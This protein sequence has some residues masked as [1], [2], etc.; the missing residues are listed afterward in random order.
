MKRH[1]TKPIL[2]EQIA[3]AR[4]AIAEFTESTRL[5]DRFF[6]GETFFGQNTHD[7]SC[8]KFLY[9]KICELGQLDVGSPQETLLASALGSVHHQESMN[10]LREKLLLEHA[11]TVIN[12][13]EAHSDWFDEI[14][15]YDES[16]D[17]Q[18]RIYPGD[19]TLYDALPDI[20]VK[21]LVYIR[22][23]AEPRDFVTWQECQLQELMSIGGII[24]DCVLESRRQLLSLWDYISPLYLSNA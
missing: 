2:R 15:P 16:P 19:Q 10:A 21:R 18:M 20:I 7:L 4:K 12:E 14:I 8:L 3:R 24:W 5:R 11:S 22:Q 1:M 23:V 13:L 17:T 9:G 6:T